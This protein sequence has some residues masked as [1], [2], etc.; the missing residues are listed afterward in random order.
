VSFSGLGVWIYS[1]S[2]DALLGEMEGTIHSAGL[3]AADGIQKWLDGRFLLVRG[4][5]D[6]VAAAAGAPEATRALVNRKVLSDTFSTAYFGVEASGAFITSNLRPLPAGY[7]PRKRPWYDA[8]VKAGDLAM[9]RPYVDATTHTLVVTIARPITVDHHLLGVVGADLPLDALASFLHS[10]DLG[11]RGFVFLVDADGVV[12]VHPDKDKIMK[13]S[14][15]NPATAQNIGLGQEHAATITRFFPITGLP[16]AKW[17]VGVSL[18]SAKIFAPLH[19]LAVVLILSV[20]A[21]MALVL[22][23]LGLLFV[24]L[25]SRPISEM[26]RAMIALSMGQ[27]EIAIPNLRRRDEIG[28]MAG[29][30]L[31]FRESMQTA[32]HLAAE[33]AA[34]R[35]SAGAEKLAALVQMA[36][37][38][39]TEA[40]AAL[41]QVSDRS[42][43]MAKTAG[44]LH[45]SAARTGAAA[46]SAVETVSQALANAQMVATATEQ[47]STSIREI[48][49]QVTQSTALVGRAVEAGKQ[50]RV[51]IEALTGQVA[52]IGAVADMISDIAARTNL[53]ALNATIEAARAGDAG[54]GFAVVANEVKQLATQTARSTGE[55]SQRIADVRAAT[56][57][58]M[59]SVNRIEQTIVEI[60]AIAVSISAAVEEQGAAT[61]EI[62]RNVTQT[63][64]AANEMTSRIDEVATEAERTDRQ[65]AEVHTNTAALATAVDGLRHSVVGVTGRFVQNCTRSG[66]S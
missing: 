55:I 13:P 50:T 24:R 21:T 8:A 27:L 54:K 22:V 39:E 52:G 59:E 60:D 2:R 65:A 15:V 10:V 12:L 7:D 36:N 46:Q 30:V 32:A 62:A 47:L 1:A 5:S 17:Y 23:L 18:E 48:G 44:E 14:G 11:G 53:L 66:L 20:T 63:A 28:A 37:A 45:D 3:S 51:D 49:G 25:V 41:S 35:E 58:S 64:T 43:A 33:Q 34:E 57:A 9:T 29:A 56:K 19:K 26:T 6:D 4:L 31:V 42:A 38:I 40:N 61:A 16:T